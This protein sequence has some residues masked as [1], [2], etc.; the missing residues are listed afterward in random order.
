[1]HEH[2]KGL[3]RALFWLYSGHGRWPTFFRWSMLAF[4]L[5][6]ISLFLIHPAISW[7]AGVEGTTGIWLAIDLFIAVIITL[8]LAAR[9]YI[10]RNKFR[11]FLRPTN[12][13]DLVVAATLLV[14]FV[15]QNL[16]FLRVFRV[17]RLVRAFEFIDR[18]HFASQWLHYNSFIVSK[19]VNLIVFVFI[20]TAFV[21]VDQSRRNPEILTYLDALYFTLSTLT[22]TGFGDITLQGT[23]GR[24]LSIVMMVL[25]VTLFLQLIRAIAVGDKIRHECPA[26]S[27]H[28]HENDAAHCRRCGA[29]LFPEGQKAASPRT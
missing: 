12:L 25:G 17:V 14:P 15:A 10:E 29:N 20:V 8:D 27:L 4:D 21:F 11:F 7:H 16:V 5:L 24:W 13:A 28:L 23:F 9:F 19:V 22:T 2:R 1:M 3:N 26:C 18:Q 6:T